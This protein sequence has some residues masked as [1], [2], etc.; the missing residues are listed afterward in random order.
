[1]H[2]PD[3]QR[4]KNLLHFFDNPGEGESWCVKLPYLTGL[5]SLL[6]RALARERKSNVMKQSGAV[7]QFVPFITF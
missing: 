5:I 7:R 1:M 3:R 2:D 6:R 4:M